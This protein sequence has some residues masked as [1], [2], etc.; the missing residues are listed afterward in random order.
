MAEF[1][2]DICTSFEAASGSEDR[3]AS[4]RFLLFLPRHT[5][6]LMVA[7]IAKT[8]TRGKGKSVLPTFIK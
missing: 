8:V 4:V 2:V 1:I 6:R 3:E 7:K 5:V